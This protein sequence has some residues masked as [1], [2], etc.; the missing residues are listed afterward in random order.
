MP[1]ICKFKFPDGTDRET[2]E[3]QIALAITTAECTY[4]HPKVRISAAYYISPGKPEVAIDVSTEVGEH[5]AQ[6]FTGLMIRQLGEDNF[7]VERICSNK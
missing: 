2:I 3:S 6:T 4:G 5:I 7:D 1:T